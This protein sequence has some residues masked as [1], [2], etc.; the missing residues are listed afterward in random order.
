MSFVVALDIG[1][2]QMSCL[3]A[4]GDKKL[5]LEGVATV[6]FAGAKKGLIVNRE[7]TIQA[8]KE[9]V[10]DA[11]RQA[12]RKGTELVVNV[13]GSHIECVSGQGIKMIIPKGRH[14]TTQDVLEVVNHSRAVLLPNDRSPIH[15]LPKTFKVDGQRGVRKPVGVAA[16][17][18]EVETLIATGSPKPLELLEQ[19]VKE[20]GFSVSQMVFTPLASGL[21]ILS[22]AEL[23]QGMIVIDLG[24]STTDLGI[25]MEGSMV[26]GI[27]LPVAAGHI[28]SDLSALLKTTLEEAERI[29]KL[30]GHA[31]ADQVGENETV[32]IQQLGQLGS[33]P[34]ARKVLS[35][36]IQSRAKEI[37]AM[38][39]TAFDQSGYARLVSGGVVLTGNGAR[40]AGTPELYNNTFGLS[41]R[42]EFTP[43][44]TSTAVGLARYAIQCAD[45]MSPVGEPTNWKDKVRRLIM[46]G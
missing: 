45:D 5:R 10:P 46:G 43:R 3:V 37:A 23:E 9:V 17:K 8:I 24:A 44:T 34:M 35:E 39:K 7:E 16:G 31:M 22:Q 13:S 26:Y 40:L 36:I 21:G 20:A 4:S 25:F 32:E 41:V 6:P 33:R 19:C 38:T 2:S 29:K 30:D 27:S 1:G 15:V 14:I 42:S 28:T 18:L 12:D 11:L